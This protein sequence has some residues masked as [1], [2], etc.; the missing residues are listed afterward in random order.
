MNIQD[1]EKIRNSKWIMPVAILI[2][3][4]LICIT[5]LIITFREDIGEH[6]AKSQEEKEARKIEQELKAKKS[7]QFSKEERERLI[8]KQGLT[9]ITEKPLGNVPFASLGK[10]LPDQ[11]PKWCTSM[12]KS[13]YWESGVLLWKRK[14]YDGFHS[15]DLRGNVILPGP[16]YKSLIIFTKKNEIRR[17]RWIL[18]IDS[19]PGGLGLRGRFSILNREYIALSYKY[20]ETYG[21][22]IEDIYEI[23]KGYEENE[24]EAFKYERA[25]ANRTYKAIDGEVIIVLNYD[26]IWIDYLLDVDNEL[27]E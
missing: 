15:C 25:K 10:Q 19:E 27:T 23:E 8:A 20:A 16:F 14:G 18:D 13:A 3:I 4:L 11:L 26:D 5:A 22:P 7:L 12:E 6:F 17:L 2:S 21:V 9:S 1:P 24:E